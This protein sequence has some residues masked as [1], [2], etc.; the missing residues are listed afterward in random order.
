MAS[1]KCREAFQGELD[2]LE[3][4]VV[5]NHI[6]FN[7]SECRILHLERDNP[8]DKHKLGNEKLKKALWK[9]MWVFGLMAG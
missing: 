4:W 2:R 7:K 3:S 8:S 6:K 1:V 9:E 5:T